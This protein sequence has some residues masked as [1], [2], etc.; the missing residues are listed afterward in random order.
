MTFDGKIAL[1][2]GA[3]S[4]IGAATTRLLAKQGAKVFAVDVNFVGLEVLVGELGSNVVPHRAE[5]TER[6]QVEGMVEAAV[7]TFG[8]LD[9]LVNNAGIGSFGAAA[10][11]DPDTWRRVM[12]IDIDAVFLASRVALPH[13][14]ARHGC[15]V[16]TASISGVGGD[17]GFT[18]YNAAKAAVI[19]LTRSMA[20]DY[21]A[22]GVRVNAV[23]PGYIATP[24]VGIMPPAVADAFV[25]NVPMKRAG[26]AAE[27]AAVIAFLASDAASYVTGHNLIADGGI[28]A[29]T[30]QPDIG[31]VLSNLAG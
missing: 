15:I 1:V 2:T 26:S 23:S 13:L 20:V 25:A 17:Y 7:K 30:G 11:L 3:A 12:A 14:I 8:A 4:G 18:A 27:I 24:L 10:D 21:A 16:N 28:T 9:I 31:R 22:Q 19:G 6:T 29:H 5:L